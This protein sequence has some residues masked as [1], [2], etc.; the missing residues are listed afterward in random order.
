V[1]AVRYHLGI[2]Y[3]ALGENV[4]AVENLTKAIELG[5]AASDFP[6]LERARA[7]VSAIGALPQSVRQSPVVLPGII[8]PA[9][10]DEDQ[11][12]G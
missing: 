5:K 8:P 1:A 10:S 11:P 6:Q 9:E 7:V 2:V 3:A 4:L 12:Q